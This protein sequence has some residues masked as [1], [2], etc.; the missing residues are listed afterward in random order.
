M[1]ANSPS[2]TKVTPESDVCHKVKSRSDAAA[3]RERHEGLTPP[4][5]EILFVR[6]LGM[7]GDAGNLGKAFLDEIFE[8]R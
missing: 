3:A 1:W 5:S 8:G 4:S 2:V 6:G 7:D